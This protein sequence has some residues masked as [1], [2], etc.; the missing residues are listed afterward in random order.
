MKSYLALIFILL[1]LVAGCT[2]PPAPAP[3]ELTQ[4]DCTEG[5]VDL[6]SCECTSCADG[7]VWNGS[8][9]VVLPLPPPPPPDPDPGPKPS[10]YVHLSRVDEIMFWQSHK[11][12][13]LFA[14]EPA[15]AWQGSRDILHVLDRCRWAFPDVFGLTPDEGEDLA[16]IGAEILWETREYIGRT[17][18]PKPPSAFYRLDDPSDKRSQDG[19]AIPNKRCDPNHEQYDPAFCGRTDVRKNVWAGFRESLLSHIKTTNLM[20]SIAGE[21]QTPEPLGPFDS[22]AGWCTEM[23][24]SG[25]RKCG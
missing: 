7:Y 5:P 9:C 13:G 8:Q 14:Y 18:N 21:C 22:I 11:W 1:M 6:E 23:G 3:C 16:Q 2:P 20:R 10:D 12:E 4:D 24:K 19:A 15:L 17:S 25:Y